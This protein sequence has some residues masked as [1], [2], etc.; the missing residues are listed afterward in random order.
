[1]LAITAKTCRHFK[2]RIYLTFNKQ[3]VQIKKV[4][5]CHGPHADGRSFTLF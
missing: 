1:M 3:T 2:V 4:S 5:S